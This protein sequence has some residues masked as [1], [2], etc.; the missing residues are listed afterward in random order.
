M[1]TQDIIVLLLIIGSSVIGALGKNRKKAQTQSSN[2]D[3]SQPQRKNTTIED[4]F[5]KARMA[6]EEEKK[7]QN[8]P[9]ETPYFDRKPLTP[10]FISNTKSKASESNQKLDT[11]PLREGIS[12]VLNREKLQSTIKGSF[13]TKSS[14]AAVVTKNR[15]SKLIRGL[16]SA[17]EL[18]KAVVYQEILNKKYF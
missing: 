15:K 12:S 18:K 17:E 11:I 1:D 2:S 9:K 6:M 16:T 13:E 14:P 10:T 8:I 4:L 5:E 3:N 7:F